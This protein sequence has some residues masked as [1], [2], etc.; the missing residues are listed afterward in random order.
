MLKVCSARFCILQCSWQLC[1]SASV[2]M[3]FSVSHVVHYYSLVLVILV[4]G[5]QDNKFDLWSCDG[6]CVADCT[7]LIF[8]L[9]F[10][11]ISLLLLWGRKVTNTM[12]LNQQWFVCMLSVVVFHNCECLNTDHIMGSECY[13]FTL[14]MMVVAGIKS[15]GSKTSTVPLKA[16]VDVSYTALP[17]TQTAVPVRSRHG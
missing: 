10:C 13:Y 14:A 3:W 17:A 5:L 1:W 11:L 6:T 12:F 2:F 16:L 9:V 8:L 7:C 15:I 4:F